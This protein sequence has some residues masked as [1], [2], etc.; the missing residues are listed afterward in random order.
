MKQWLAER[1]IHY[2]FLLFSAVLGVA[3][4]VVSVWADG[5]QGADKRSWALIAGVSAFGVVLITHFEKRQVEKGKKR[6]EDRAIRAEADMAKLYSTTLGPLSNRIKA[7]TALYASAA[8]LPSSVPAQTVSGLEQKRRDVLDAVLAGAVSLTAPPVGPSY[9]PRARCSFYLYNAATGD[10]TLERSFPGHR[11]PRS[12]IDPV[13]AAHMKNAILD[14]GKTFRLDGDQEKHSYLIPV[15]AGYEA[16]IA[17]PVI[18]GTE[19]IGIL[20]VDAPRFS[21]FFDPHV[22]LME[23]L[24]SILAASYALR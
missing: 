2:L 21:D 19:K 3:V 16:V 13:G 14:P 1:G 9:I 18:Y 17:V 24:A 6:A 22:T 7:L 8:P 11:P 12:V 10:F 5:A 23:S 20:S 4:A 15:G